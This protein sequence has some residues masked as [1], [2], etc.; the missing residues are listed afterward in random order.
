MAGDFAAEPEGNASQCVTQAM[1][2]ERLRLTAW[3]A[4]RDNR[5]RAVISPT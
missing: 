3:E 5:G 2:R 4:I 1:P